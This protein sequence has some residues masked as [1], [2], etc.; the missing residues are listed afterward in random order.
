M[1]TSGYIVHIAL[2]SFTFSG[3]GWAQAVSTSQISGTIQDSSG[4]AVPGAEVKVTQTD[5]GAIRA[6]VSGPDGAYVIP[7]LPVGPYSLEVTKEGFTRYVQT[8]IVLQVA[9]NPAIPVTL[10][11]GAVSERIQVEAN[12]A[13][14]ETQSTG[15][16]QVIDSQRV[17]DLPLVGRQVTDLVVL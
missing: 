8:G 7:S 11:V 6:V 4:L 9:T 17:L 15:V 13:M 12:A 16:G 2:L 10:K 1:K 5:T 3:L 14:V